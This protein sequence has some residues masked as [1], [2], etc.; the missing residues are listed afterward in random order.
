MIRSILVFTSVKFLEVKMA[1]KHALLYS[2]VITAMRIEV[3]A[4]G[5]E[6]LLSFF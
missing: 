5:E 2:S 3:Q 1:Y 4:V 6:T